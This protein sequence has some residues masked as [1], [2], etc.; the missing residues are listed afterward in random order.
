VQIGEGKYQMGYG[1]GA[2]FPMHL[3]MAVYGFN[4]Q[5]TVQVH[6]LNPETMGAKF[7]HIE[8]H[9]DNHRQ[10]GVD[11]GEIPGDDR[12]EGP[13]YGKFSAIFLGKIAER[14]YFGFHVS[15][16]W[17]ISLIKAIY[18]HGSGKMTDTILRA[19]RLFFALCV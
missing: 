11:T 13:H 4:I 10:L 16:E 7:P 18:G 6:G 19:G 9:P 1:G 3:H 8:A 17:S 15:K 14:K 2:S 12:I 5:F